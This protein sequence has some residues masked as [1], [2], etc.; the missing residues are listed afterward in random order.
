MHVNSS[1]SVVVFPYSN[2]AGINDLELLSL[3]GV[4]VAMGNACEVV[5]KSVDHVAASNRHDG[6]AAFMREFVLSYCD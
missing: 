2:S 4:G 1:A 5:K 6:F 3:A